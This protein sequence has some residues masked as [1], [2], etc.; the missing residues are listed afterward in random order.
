MVL[1][2][3]VVV[4]VGGEVGSCSMLAGEG[5]EGVPQ[6]RCSIAS[7]ANLRMVRQVPASSSTESM[8]PTIVLEK[9]RVIK[10]EKMMGGEGLTMYSK[11]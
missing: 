2:V 9:E 11:E 5:E 7:T 1:V 8:G 10:R 4:V 6:H 3:V